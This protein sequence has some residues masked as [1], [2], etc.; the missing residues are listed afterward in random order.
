[1]SL[2]ENKIAFVTGAAMGNGEGIARVMAEK[3]A[4]VIL[5][6]IAPVVFETVK[7]VE[8]AVAYQVDISD[9][10][11]VQEVADDVI[12]KFG[13]L[14]ILVNNAGI[15]RMIRVEN[16]D[17]ALRDF[18]WRVNVVGCWNCT[19]SFIPHMIE[20][21]YGRI[22]NMSSVTGPRV[23]DPGMMGYAISKAGILGFTKAIAMDVAQ[24]GIT[25][26]A[27]LPG[28]FL[29]P[30]VRHSAHETDPKNPQRVLDGIAAKVPLGRF[31]DPRE[32]GYL[33]AFIASD[34]AAYITGA[35]FLIDGGSTL[36]ETGAMGVAGE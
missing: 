32:I 1:M 29:T 35:E 16:M 34:E 11:K 28:Y 20:R 17:D 12:Q 10:E 25:S 6:D 22:V 24:Y 3:G 26:N 36:P 30:M 33:A 27:I 7:T 31:G 8:R 14:D 21:R 15:A 9:A 2:L 13:R 18:H 5:A 19:K 4:T 23:V